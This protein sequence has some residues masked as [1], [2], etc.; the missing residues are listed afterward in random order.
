MVNCKCHGV[1]GSCEIKTCWKAA[2]SLRRIGN[3]LKAKFDAAKR[4]QQKRIGSKRLLVKAGGH[5]KVEEVTGRPGL[6]G[7]QTAMRPVDGS[8]LVFSSQSPDF[9]EPNPKFGF[10][11]TQGRNCNRT[12]G[13]CEMLCCGRG[14]E[15]KET[16]VVERCRCKFR[17][18][19]DVLCDTCTTY[20]E[21]SVCR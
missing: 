5:A 15:V 20:V 11:G 9:C 10:A 4:V 18:C 14:H 17:F 13:D 21:Q 7:A 6:T 2:P 16:R 8:N 12:S 19:C 3:V 1:S